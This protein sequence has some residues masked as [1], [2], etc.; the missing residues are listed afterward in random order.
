MEKQKEERGKVE[1]GRRCLP[2]GYAPFPLDELITMGGKNL[3]ES[4]E[5]T[6]GK[7]RERQ[8]TH[9]IERS[10][11]GITPIRGSAL[12]LPQ[13][14]ITRSSLPAERKERGPPSTPSKSH[15]Y[16]YRQATTA[17]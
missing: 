3:D 2:K 13:V 12:S 4:S 1:F 5:I 10:F 16:P 6:T 17:V 7:T 15:P 11:A 8:S 14:A 9:A